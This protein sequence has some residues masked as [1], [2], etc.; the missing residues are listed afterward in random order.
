MR[1]TNLKIA[2]V[3]LWMSMFALGMRSQRRYGE[4]FN[5]L[6]LDMMHG[7]P[8]NFV[9]DIFADSDG[10]IWI[11][12]HGGGLVRYDGYSFLD[13][14][15]GSPG[16]Q[17][18]SN[19]CRNICEDRFH[20]LWV[21]FDEYTEVLDLNTLAPTIPLDKQRQ[22]ERILKE[23][24][25]HVYCDTKGKIWI[26]TMAHIYCLLF[27]QDGMVSQVLQYPY[28]SNTPDVIIK[29]IDENGN[30][31]VAMGGSLK[32][33]SVS[34]DKLVCS[35]ISPSL[36]A[37]PVAFIGDVMKYH[38]K[39]WI[40]TNNGLYCYDQYINKVSAYHH[41]FTPHSLSHDYVSSL[42]VTSDNR[43]V[44]GTLRG[45]D[46]LNPL[47]GEIEHGEFS[48]STSLSNAFVN[49][50]RSIYGQLWIG[51]EG[52]GVMRF[53]PRQLQMQN[54]VH[55]DDPQSLSHFAVNAIYVQNDGTLWVGTVEGGLNRK[56]NG[57][58]GFTHYTTANTHLSHNSVSAFAIDNQQRMWVGTWA[59]G[60]NVFPLDA[61]ERVRPLDVSPS[62]KPLLNFIG[63]LQYDPIN[64]ALW[65]GS[66]DGIYF[67]DLN[68]FVMSDPFPG[69][70]FFR[71]CIGSTIL[72]DHKLWMGCLEGAVVI[73]L[74]KRNAQGFAYQHLKYKLDDPQS[75]TIDKIA[76]FCLSSNGTLWL[77]S[78]GYGLYKRIV[79][80]DGRMTFKAY[81]VEDGLANNA[82]K[83]IAEDKN[84]MLWITTM[85]GLSHFNPK[86]GVFT[87][88][89]EEDGLVSSQFYWNS[90]VSTN[91]GMLY[92]GTDKGLIGIYGENNV[93][94][95]NG[96]LH[97]TQLT[98]NNQVAE[99]G[100]RHID[101]NIALAKHINLKES[102]KSF[103]IHF[104]ALHY[105]NSTQGIYS[106]RMKGFEQQWISLPAGQN[107]VR[108][109]SIQPG[110]YVFEVK[111][112]SA[113]DN[114]EITPISID[115]HV[116]PYFWKS[117]WF[118][119]LLLIAL[120]LLTYYYYRKLQQ[121][122]IRQLELAK[123]EEA[124]RLI[125]PIEKVLRESEDP[126]LL[127]QRIQSILHNQQRFKE[128]SLKSVQADAEEMEK[129]NK[130]FMERAMEIMEKNYM[131]SEFGVNEFCQQIGMSR[132]LLSKRFNEHVGQSTTQFI[133][134]YRLDIAKQIIKRGDQRNIAEIAFSVGFNDPKYFTRCFTK[135][136]VVSPS[137]MMEQ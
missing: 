17:L 26:A 132:S 35:A 12:T 108:Y 77:G 51:T 126:Y 66:N 116:E 58:N 43:L 135:L 40:A 82:V 86:T 111:Y 109:T 57:E 36:S 21:S 74:K 104:S 124:E 81:R 63:A 3:F 5:V 125:R 54:F 34:N 24:S 78:N 46:I 59:G 10:F 137:T 69:C 60:I 118:N 94:I 123:K 42:T 75:G 71:G 44:I 127:Q 97:F 76:C 1:F 88:F 102:D 15:V 11:A 19:S 79:K 73:D 115:I 96:K 89:H 112:A 68:T 16:R 38:E 62:Y 92:L 128:S 110:D 48:N 37:L 95:Y 106:Y 49:C 27:R 70:R 129:N 56:L 91:N 64:N 84:G 121:K 18:K 101:C 90:A 41:D 136:Y 6:H 22:M 134:N 45:I 52:G 85:H 30:V 107:S 14:G 99:P 2:I 98:V 47:S 114:A 29:D 72:P 67:Y 25:L 131:D 31:W 39:Y 105:G 80:Q 28:R 130:P 20:R 9:D 83:G 133:R 93:N 87:N 119:S 55:T 122:R 65:I 4:R 120:V 8:N 117:W 61:P 100:G 13:F 50:L 23:R 7:L 33:M 113:L 103:T 53:V 32:R